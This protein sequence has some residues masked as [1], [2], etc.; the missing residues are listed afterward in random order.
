[1]NWT[2]GRLQ[3]S[4]RGKR[5][6]LTSE[7]KAYFSRAKA[8][9]LKWLSEKQSAEQ[10]NNQ[11]LYIEDESA[12]EGFEVKRRSAISGRLGTGVRQAEPAPQSRSSDNLDSGLDSE[13]NAKGSSKSRTGK[14]TR[15]GN[16]SSTSK[17]ARARRSLLLQ[18][19]WL[20]LGDRNEFRHK[21]FDG[22]TGAAR[23]RHH[24]RGP[25]RPNPK[26]LSAD[27]SDHGGDGVSSPSSLSSDQELESR[28][29]MKEHSKHKRNQ[30]R[31]ALYGYELVQDTTHQLSH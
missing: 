21:E 12:H 30:E 1:M 6:D 19:Q 2:G 17:V 7:Q 27:G 9:R 5:G 3:Q 25:S 29:A 24:K 8:R 26:H 23:R 20:D 28:A 14:A 10:D 22:D 13:S 4:K 16:T 31:R 11:G 15:E 18:P